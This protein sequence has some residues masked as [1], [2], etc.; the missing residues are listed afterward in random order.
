MKAGSIKDLNKIEN[1][2]VGQANKEKTTLYNSYIRNTS[3]YN[4]GD[5]NTEDNKTR[6]SFDNIVSRKDNNNIIPTNK[7]KII[8]MFTKVKTLQKIKRKNQK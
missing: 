6:K 1:K 5:I 7:R 2:F 8:I 3:K 4:K